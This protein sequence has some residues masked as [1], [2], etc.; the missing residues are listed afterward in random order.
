MAKVIWGIDFG[1]WSLKVVRASYDKK[2]D[3]LT[4][5]LY[6]EFIYGE[7]PCGYEASPLDKHREGIIAFQK[8]YSIGSGED[9]CVA[10]TGSEVFS[11][12]INLPP[13]AESLDQII[14]YEARQQIPFDINDVVWDYQRVKQ[15]QEAPGEEIEVGLFALK[16]ERVVELLDLLAPWRTNLR[17]IQNAPLAVYNF[18]EYEKRVGEA[19]IVLDVGGATADVLVLNPPRYW[20]RTLLVAGNDLTNALVQKM[21]VSVQEAELIKSRTGRSAHR[22]QILHTLQPVF[23]EITNEVQRSLGYYKSLVRDVKFERIL[24]LGNAMRL[25]GMQQVLGGGLQYKVEPLR[26]LR[27]I[28]VAG[29]VDKE[30]LHEALPGA[31]AA[32][33]LLVQGAGQGRITINMVPEDIATTAEISRKKPWILAAAAGVLAIAGLLIAA[34]VLYAQDLHRAKAEGRWGVVDEAQTVQKQYADALAAANALKAQIQAVAKPGVDRGTFLDL[35]GVLSDSLPDDVYLVTLDF[36]WMS[37]GSLPSAASAAAPATGGFPTGMAAGAGM[38]A[39]A[40]PPGLGGMGGALFPTSATP[41]ADA[42]SQLVMSFNAETSHSRNG[43]DYVNTVIDSLGKATYPGTQT[44]AFSKVVLTVKP[45]DVWRKAATGEAVEAPSG[46]AIEGN[47]EILHFLSFAGA[48]VV[49]PK[50]GAAAAKPA[51]VAASGAPAASVAPV[52]PVKTP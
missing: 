48:A 11:R 34:E 35:L 52:A 12:F 46:G 26:E 17:I 29:S 16:R 43:P 2:S 36:D 31:C 37:P 18:L 3:T 1:N 44:P 30:K 6:D 45:R 50:V 13:V 33:G 7:L 22:E 23:D 47:E 10:V 38:A 49:S 9:L 8:K 5:D 21:G 14:R 28:Q 42:S 27:R 32:L 40:G 51:A 24:A 39:M 25:E 4:V 41:R 15:E 20:V 19:C